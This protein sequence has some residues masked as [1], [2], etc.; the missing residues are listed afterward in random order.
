MSTPAPAPHIWKNYSK[1]EIV[2]LCFAYGNLLNL[3]GTDDGG[4]ANLPIQG[5]QMLWALAGVESSFGANCKPRYE[6]AY[7]PEGLY[8]RQSPSMRELYRKY[9]RDAA[10]SYGPW[11]LM[12]C[13]A[14]GYTP[15]ELATDP[16][17][18]CQA[19]IGFINR[20]VIGV[21]YARTLEQFA[22]VFNS[23]TWRDSVTPQVQ[24]YIRKVTHNYFN[25]VIAL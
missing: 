21:R 2:K 5:S 9:G 25:E 18:A 8:Y 14:P 3:E 20:F 15:Y 19:T 4:G 23:G 1:A 10:A 24:G 6:S 16:E 22:D 11:Q 17:K 12:L 13:N 7:M